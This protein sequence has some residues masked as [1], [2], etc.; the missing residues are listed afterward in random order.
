M[1]E[2]Q[3]EL[4]ALFRYALVRQATDEQLTPRQRGA[5]VR[6]LAEQNHTGPDGNTLRISR[7]TLDRWIL[8]WRTGGFEALKPVPRNS[9]M[10]TSEQM[11]LLAVQLKQE[12]P[13][14]T[15][16]R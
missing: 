8:A 13:R 9:R 12:V 6:A 1:D 11:L 10:R 3:R 15:A 5:L 4:V 16:A 2:K 7:S 14:R